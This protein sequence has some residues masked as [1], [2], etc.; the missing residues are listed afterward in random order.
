M[1]HPVA[2]SASRSAWLTPTVWQLHWVTLRHENDSFQERLWP[3]CTSGEEN[4]RS[5]RIGYFTGA[6]Q[7][8]V[9]ECNSPF[10]VPMTGQPALWTEEMVRALIDCYEHVLYVYRDKMADKQ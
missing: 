5:T 2:K 6:S 1:W 8:D 4:P 3:R 7:V 10:S 9:P